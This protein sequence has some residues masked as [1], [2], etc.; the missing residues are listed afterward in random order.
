MNF[1][2]ADTLSEGIGRGQDIPAAVS[3]RK[4]LSL[5]VAAAVV[6]VSLVSVHDVNAAPKKSAKKSQ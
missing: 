3:R 6:G 1:S 5:C 2:L 4:R